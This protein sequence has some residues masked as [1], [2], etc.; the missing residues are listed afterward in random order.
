MTCEE[1]IEI[2]A[3]QAELAN[4]FDASEAL[5][6]FSTSALR[7]E[8]VFSEKILSESKKEI[9]QVSCLI[10]S[11]EHDAI[12]KT[13]T[14]EDYHAVEE[15]QTPSLDLDSAQIQSHLL[16]TE[17]N[18]KYREK[19]TMTSEQMESFESETLTG[20]SQDVVLENFAKWPEEFSAQVQITDPGTLPE[21]YLS[22]NNTPRCGS[23]QEQGS[24]KKGK[25]ISNYNPFESEEENKSKET[26]LNPFDYEEEINF[27]LQVEKSIVETADKI[28][29]L[30]SSLN[31]QKNN[32]K[33]TEE[34][35]LETRDLN[36]DVE[37]IHQDDQ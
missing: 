26:I 23:Q 15:A 22:S 34:K 8:K 4:I 5:D 32:F 1:L 6:I 16:D 7:E 28:D 33:M 14:P 30:A 9:A 10:P 21:E 20:K 3:N 24:C 31:L 17:A 29:A 37:N 2:D 18:L 27:E 13:P 11:E 19:R 35:V 36:L 12:A 25:L